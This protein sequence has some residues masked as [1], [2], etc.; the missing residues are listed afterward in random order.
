MSFR[1]DERDLDCTFLAEDELVLI[2]S[3]K[4]FLAQKMGV[5]FEDLRDEAVVMMDVSTSSPWHKRV[6]E[7]FLRFKIPFHLQV[8]NAPIEALKKMVAIGLGVG[9]VPRLCVQQEVARGELRIV[10]I[11]GF[12]ELRSVWL[13][14][15]WALESQGADAFVEVASTF[16]AQMRISFE[17]GIAQRKS[18]QGGVGKSPGLTAYESVM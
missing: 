13:V 6:D 11:Q 16:A 9:F 3:A 12:R 10:E 2:T 8:E 17:G 5:Q 7:A 14:R 18:E 4:H 15:R 1:P